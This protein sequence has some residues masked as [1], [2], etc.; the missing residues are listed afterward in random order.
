MM[1]EIRLIFDSD[2]DGDAYRA[3]PIYQPPSGQ[4]FQGQAVP[5]TFDLDVDQQADLRWYLEEYIDLPVHGS[6][7][8]A[9][10]I[11][12]DI[13][14]WGREL[15][16]N[17]FGGG[18]NAG[19]LAHMLDDDGSPHLTVATD[20]A[21]VLRLPWELLADDRGPLAR[22]VSIR[23]QLAS[24]ADG[25]DF[26]VELPLRILLVVS[27]PD[28]LGFIDPRLTTRSILD[29]LV[30]LGEQNVVVDFCRPPTLARLDEMLS[31]AGQ[32]GEPYTI[33][34]FDGHGTYDPVL[35]LGLLCFERSAPASQTQ[36]G[37]ETDGVRAER[38][39]QL[40]S[41]HRIPLAILEACR[42][43]QMDNLVAL[44]GVAPRLIA[45][46]VGSVVAMSYA[47]HVEATRVLLDR[48]YRELVAGAS[49]G[50]ALDEGRAALIAQPHRWIE[51]GP[52][53]RTVE[54][55]DWF[56]PQLYQRGHDLTLV[57][58]SSVGHVSNVPT[59][60][61]IV[62][63]ESTFDVFLS[64]N[65]ADKDR[66][67]SIA[68][69]LRDRHGLRVWFDGWKL[70]S[71]PLQRACEAGVAASRVVVICCTRAALE[72]DWVEAERQM[73]TA[74]DDPMGENII[75]VLLEDVDLPLGLKSLLHYDLRDRGEDEANVARLA[76]AIGGG[77]PI[78][79]GQRTPPE[80]GQLGAFP[81]TP[82]HK[83]QG[84]ARELYQLEQQLR[85]DRAIV[86]HAMGG[87]GKTAL[88]RE[89]AYWWTRTGLF[90]DGACF[91]SFEQPTSPEQVALV[92]GTYLEGDGFE[93]LAQDE[94]RRR[95]RQLFQEKRV[96]MV[97]DNFE[98]ILPQ[99]AQQEQALK[100]ALAEDENG[101][102]NG[103]G[104]DQDDRCLSQFSP[105]QG[106][107]ND[108]REMFADWTEDERG[109]GQLLVTSRPEDTGLAGARRF[110]LHGLAQSDSLHLLHRVMQKTGI[111]PDADRLSR[112]SLDELV[113]T[114]GHHPLS[115]ELV[116]PHLRQLAPGEIIADF[117]SLL[118]H[119]TGEAELE[120][121]RS[122]LASLRFSTDRLSP[123]AQAAL[124]WLGLFRGGVFEDNLLDISQIDPATWDGIRSELEAT[125]LVRIETDI[126]ISHR[127]YLRFHP[128]LPF[129]CVGPAC[130]AGP[131]AGT[132]S[133]TEVGTDRA[134]RAGPTRE[135]Y[136]QVYYSLGAT[137]NS[138]L[139]GSDPRGGMEV[140]A[141]E[142]ANFRQ[143]VEWAV[144][145][146]DFTTAA[147]IGDTFRVY[148]ES[149]ARFRERDRWAAWLAEAAAGA[150]WS[151]AAA[152]AERQA[153]WS[154]FTQGEAA[155]A[156]QRITALIQRLEQS[157][158]FDPAFQ[159]ALA[160]RI[161]GRMYHAA[162]LSTQAIPILQQTVQD[163]ER[164]AASSS[165]GADGDESARG[166][167][168]RATTADPAILSNLSATLG[169]LANAF[170]A[171]GRLDEALEA[172]ERT[173]A[174]VD[175]LGQDRDVAASLNISAKILA[176]QG[177]Y[178]EADQRYEQALSA[179]RRAGD[180]TSEAL[181]LQNHGI[182]AI[183]TQQYDRATARLKPALR[184][185]QE[186][187]NDGEVMRTCNVLGAVEH[188][189]GRLA[190]ARAW[191]ERSREIALR[192]QDQESLGAAA[193]NLGIVCQDEGKEHREQDREDQARQQFA[194]AERFLLE[195]LDCWIDAGNKP[196]EAASQGQ[197]GRLYLLMDQLDKAEEHAQRAREI[198]EEL[199]DLR[200]LWWVYQ[201]LND[202]ATARDDTAAAQQWAAKEQALDEELARRARGGDEDGGDMPGGVLQMLTQLAVVCVQAAVN[203]SPL[204]PDA[205]QLLSQMDSPDAGP[206]EPLAAYLRRLSTA[207]PT[208][209]VQLLSAP[210]P[211][212]PDPL[213]NVIA[214]LKDAVREAL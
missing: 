52:G 167:P 161:L 78:A 196:H 116:G 203:E 105:D 118:E 27:R 124:P 145:D 19:L 125:A 129:A 177:R 141:R 204:P 66:L 2:A 100:Q 14:R 190:E 154:Q 29:A 142:E 139:T 92:L 194:E 133:T 113:R 186:S 5:L 119:F 33:V 149:C 87:M 207:P 162:G 69:R 184:L 42:S 98:S 73:A 35:G 144:S 191:Y 140:M 202:I 115:I 63:H 81:R 170:R 6:Q 25:D 64:H 172:A 213:P 199:G 48:F 77:R 46:G 106:V 37:T 28:D 111:E 214:Q 17:V 187:S 60:D 134:C 166:E 61:E 57:E 174:I 95:A 36:A 12:Q 103:I 99:F 147:P 53:G 209:L 195:S 112:E 158:E 8:R 76:A 117:D 50:Q 165:A 80:R 40:L 104:S 150:G 82:L 183:Q 138:A 32:R 11:E 110:E 88:A 7:V 121:N 59:H 192:R 4:P 206:L 171:A 126:Q 15:F 169:D 135:R 65:H 90:P 127:P 85:T 175:Q 24:A 26:L 176:A 122:L 200:L 83:F 9:G 211:N 20:D 43:G 151:E 210:P 89:A 67:E 114:L 21:H 68:R 1:G 55:K 10:R 198:G 153:A 156:I 23:R 148:L 97:W 131:C 193:Q 44:R 132:D 197:L 157:D 168:T 72:S 34:H 79:V 93:Q 178:G 102:E 130:R 205:Q 182:L 163:W 41:A 146:G 152:D 56:L 16:D 189:Q 137:I 136:I 51:L 62:P 94:Q 159:L 45:A 155:A 123:A 212:L 70:T 71:G 164:L 160:K 84:R 120:R 107:I 173:T 13:D 179:A 143:A 47:V 91:V 54:L 49:I 108:I 30:P 38:L 109:H 39:G 180:R 101:G 185:F 75:P 181:A 86:L 18:A 208:D 58:S 201:Y 31:A 22:R 74:K 188:Q 3:Q 128:T 96:L